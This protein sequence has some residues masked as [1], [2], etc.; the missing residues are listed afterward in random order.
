MDTI[1][2]ILTNATLY[3]YRWCYDKQ[4][5]LFFLTGDPS[6]AP[7]ARYKS[8]V[9]TRLRTLAK[10]NSFKDLK[11]VFAG[12]LERYRGGQKYAGY[13]S[14]RVDSQFRLIFLWKNNRAIDIQIVDYHGE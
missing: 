6:N 13:C 5:N 8:L 4:T 2:K 11:H 12:T 10:I 14:V 3:K 9:E 7:W 1:F